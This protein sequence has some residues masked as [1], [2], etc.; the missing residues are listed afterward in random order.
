MINLKDGKESG[1][2]LLEIT[3]VCLVAAVVMAIATPK[4]TRAMREYRLN[5][6]LRQLSDIIQKAKVEAVAENRKAS[7][8]VDSTNRKV[9]L[10]VYDANLTVIRTEYIPLP[11]GVVF[12]RP[13]NLTP[14]I[15]GAPTNKDIS[16]P[17]QNG[18]TT[19]FQQDFTSRGFPSVASAGAINA[20]YLGDG[21]NYRALTL[22]SVGGIGTWQWRDN[23]WKSL[24]G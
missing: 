12:V 24:K 11:Q 1:F 9:G 15:S 13:A 4:I 5:I 3:V 6:T 19:V 20:I 21:T 7:L 22:T 10:I 17:G 8:V 18:S 14:P 16:F 23:T 2:S